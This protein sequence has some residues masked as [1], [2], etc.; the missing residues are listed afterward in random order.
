MEKMDR[1]GNGTVG[2]HNYYYMIS[3]PFEFPDQS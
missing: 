3:T 2:Y 1:I